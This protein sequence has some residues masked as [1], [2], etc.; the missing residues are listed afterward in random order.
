VARRPKKQRPTEQDPDTVTY[1]RGDI[2]AVLRDLNLIVVNLDRIGSA[3]VGE[4][5]ATSHQWLYEFVISWRVFRR[6]AEARAILSDAFSYALGPDDIDELARLMGEVPKWSH[7]H[8]TA[9]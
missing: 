8:R 4:D 3:S 6:L 2:V 5:E 9:P 1:K 7:D